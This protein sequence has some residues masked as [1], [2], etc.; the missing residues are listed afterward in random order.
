MTYWLAIWL[1]ANGVVTTI[2]PQPYQSERSC[3]I[4][5]QTW[6]ENTDRQGHHVCIPMNKVPW[7]DR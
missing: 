5:G 4:A 2:V 7:E 1:S 6:R 3:A